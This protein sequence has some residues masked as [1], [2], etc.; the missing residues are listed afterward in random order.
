MVTVHRKTVGDR[1]RVIYVNDVAGASVEIFYRL[2]KCDSPLIQE[3]NSESRGL[4]ILQATGT[5]S[6]RMLG[7]MYQVPIYSTTSAQYDSGLRDDSKQGNAHF[8]MF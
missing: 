6:Y 3:L 1:R 2:G 7:F 5:V 4:L 8:S